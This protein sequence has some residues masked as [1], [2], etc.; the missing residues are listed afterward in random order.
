MR[1]KSSVGIWFFGI[2]SAK[3][4]KS[5]K[6]KITGSRNEETKRWKGEGKGGEDRETRKDEKSRKSVVCAAI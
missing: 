4:I 3:K 1:I 6:L 5:R 2:G